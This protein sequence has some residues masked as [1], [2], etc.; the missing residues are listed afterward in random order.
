MRF[1]ATAATALSLCAC[2]MPEVGLFFPIT[3]D[4]YT[5]PQNR[6]PV[7]L[8]QEVGIETSDGLRLAAI[9]ATQH[10]GQA[11]PTLLY[12]HG[13]GG[14]IDEYWRWVTLLW[15]TGFNVLIV[16]YRGFGKSEGKPTEAGVY[17][18]ARAALAHLT[19]HSGLDGDRIGFWGY[20]LGTAVATE[21]A[22]AFSTPLLVLEAPLTSI[23]DIV[24]K[25]APYAIP[26]DWVTDA[27]FDTHARIGTVGSPVVIVHGT[28]D[29]R[30]P[31]WMGQRVFEAAAEPKR[32]VRID[33]GDHDG[34]FEQAS[35]R[36]MAAVSEIVP[37]MSPK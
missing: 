21:L 1:C 28:K 6:V 20:S 37:V 5:L 2:N 14:N 4:A 15:E 11:A 25:S 32:F 10:D 31:F 7:A 19:S 34:P 24:E 9:L 36:T 26:A 29:R 33:G 12:L 22:T 8:L 3:V 30:V 16:D 35:E 27:S 18:D 23:I 17:L 13:Q